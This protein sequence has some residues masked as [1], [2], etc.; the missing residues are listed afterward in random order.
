MVADNR[1]KEMKTVVGKLAIAFCSLVV[2]SSLSAQDCGALL[3]HGIKNIEVKYSS[4]AAIATKYYRH[5]GLDFKEVSDSILANIEVEIIGSGSGSGGFSRAQ[6]EEALRR[7]CVTNKDVAQSSQS[8]YHKSQTIMADAISAWS[9]CSE[10]SAKGVQTRPVVSADLRTV[11]LSVSFTG[12]TSEIDYYG[13]DAEGF[14][15]NSRFPE[16]YGRDVEAHIKAGNAIKLRAGP[17]VSVVCS[18]SVAEKELNGQVYEWL[19]RGTI[20]IRTGSDPYQMFFPE[21]TNPK[22]PDSV[23]E[24]LQA[25]VARL[26]R[27]GTPVGAVVGFY[28]SA[29]E[30]DALAPVWL[31]ADGRI[32]VDGESPLN[33]RKL[34]D[35]N[36]RVLLGMKSGVD[37]QDH[38]SSSGGTTELNEK[39][40]ISGR[41]GELQN[42]SCYTPYDADVRNKFP[43]ANVAVWD[44]K[45]EEVGCQHI[46]EHKD[47]EYEFKGKLPLPPFQGVV[48][49]VKVR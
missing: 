45:S 34:P 28:L 37:L 15:C 22:M 48:Y 39:W 49:M 21:S 7:W 47:S 10:L 5:C 6:R 9:K 40:K 43:G 3:T 32:L 8:D 1:E 17:A 18:R 25:E 35:L 16:M 38:K 46:H 36:G 23:A 24:A 4:E 30:I 20:S 41:T 31:P 44:T 13:F 42:T 14:E 33:G 29:P 12:P 27:L 26:R 2:S 19:S 11:T